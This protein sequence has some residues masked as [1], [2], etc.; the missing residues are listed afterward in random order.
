MSCANHSVIL[1]G[2]EIDKNDRG[3]TD[4]DKGGLGHFYIQSFIFLLYLVLL[5]AGY[6]SLAFILTLMSALTECGI[7]LDVF[8]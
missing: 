5:N 2:T 1:L 8:Y 6:L 4:L 7:D 3:M